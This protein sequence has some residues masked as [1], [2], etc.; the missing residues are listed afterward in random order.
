M[1]K[2]ELDEG[3][4]INSGSGG[5]AR[6][7][8]FETVI[9]VVKFTLSILLLPLVWGLTVSFSQE[10]SNQSQ[11][12]INNFVLAIAAYLILHMFI[13]EP[14]TI[15][16]FGQRLISGMFGFIAPLRDLLSCAVPF[17][18][19]LT[20]GLYF[21]FKANFAYEVIIGYFIFWIS[22]TAVMHLILTAAYMKE[23][24][25]DT[26]KGNYFFT[27]F[28]VYMFEIVLISVFFN[29]MLKDFS[30]V[31]IIK[32]GGKFFIDTHTAIFKQLFVMK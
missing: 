18:T 3:L 12:I 16:K 28:L 6:G 13:Y 10:F 25:T 11:D 8:L 20:F 14:N 30:F 1:A 9:S 17:Y 19:V 26:L 5:R 2:Q 4:E 23:E 24:T 15:Y 31:N 29:V 21:I 22:F 32:S 7:S 27:L